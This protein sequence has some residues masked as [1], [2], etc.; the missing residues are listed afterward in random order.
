MSTGETMAGDGVRGSRGSK[1]SKLAMKGEGAGPVLREVQ[2]VGDG[3]THSE[4]SRERTGCAPQD[5]CGC[6]EYSGHP[7]FA[8][9][10]S[11][12]SLSVASRNALPKKRSGCDPV[13][14][15]PYLRAISVR[16]SV[17]TV[18]T[19]MKGVLHTFHVDVDVRTHT[20]L[21]ISESLLLLVIEEGH[22]RRNGVERK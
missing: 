2:S 15:A 12:A 20:L 3:S 11:E 1:S 22:L 19:L 17:N 8:H 16:T 14:M 5:R 6:G 4:G 10:G 18:S 13:V 7:I 9:A 21:D